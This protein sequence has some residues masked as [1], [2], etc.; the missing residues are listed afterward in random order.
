MLA[1]VAYI[2]SQAMWQQLSPRF[3][4]PRPDGWGLGGKAGYVFVGTNIFF[5]IYCYFRLPETMGRTFGELDLMFAQRLPARKFKTTQ[6]NGE[7]EDTFSFQHELNEAD[8]G[9]RI[10]RAC[11]KP[12]ECIDCRRQGRCPPSRATLI[13]SGCSQRQEGV[14]RMSSRVRHSRND[15][16]AIWHGRCRRHGTSQVESYP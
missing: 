7:F 3:L 5:F 6:L 12:S 10:W 1:R 4:T 2:L 9:P 13:M 11:C 15:A 14:E 16:A 8:P